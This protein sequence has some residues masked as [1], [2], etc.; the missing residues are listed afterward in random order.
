MRSR[1]EVFFRLCCVMCFIVLEFSVINND[2]DL[3]ECCF[4]FLCR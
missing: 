4:C 2:R 3:V 1:Y